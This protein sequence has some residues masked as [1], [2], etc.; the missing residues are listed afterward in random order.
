MITENEIRNQLEIAKS[1]LGDYVHPVS[2]TEWAF[3]SG[4]IR[5]L[6]YALGQAKAKFNK[7]DI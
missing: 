4:Y 6:A 1:L 7:E 2:E 3:S 5:A